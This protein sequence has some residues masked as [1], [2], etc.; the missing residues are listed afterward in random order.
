M[1]GLFR[2]AD[3]Y[4]V[5][6]F[7]TKELLARSRA[8]FRREERREERYSEIAS[9]QFYPERYEVACFGKVLKFS[10][11]EFKLLHLLASN[12]RQTFSAERLHTLLYPE[13][14]GNTASL[15]LRIHISD[16]PKKCKQEGLQ[17]IATVRGVGYRWQLEPE[18]SKA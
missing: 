10:E 5:K 15:H 13:S 2:G 3:D 1:E 17:A 16:L 8:H 6:P 9:C 14:S 18:I 4:I 12:P 7:G 11:R